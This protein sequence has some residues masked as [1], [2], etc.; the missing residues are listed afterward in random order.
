MRTAHRCLDGE[1]RGGGRARR[2]PICATCLWKPKRK[3][4]EILFEENVSVWFDGRTQKIPGHATA[5][6]FFPFLFTDWSKAIYGPQQNNG[7]IVVCSTS[8]WRFVRSISKT[9]CRLHI[10][11]LVDLIMFTHANRLQ[12]TLTC[13]F[14]SSSHIPH[15]ALSQSQYFDISVSCMLQCHHW[16]YRYVYARQRRARQ[17]HMDS[18]T[19]SCCRCT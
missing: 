16:R 2:S 12:I 7:R 9:L 13:F 18:G 6:S 17:C 1:R 4:E 8:N 11:V 19:Y 3:R 10:I 5:S 15:A 14:F